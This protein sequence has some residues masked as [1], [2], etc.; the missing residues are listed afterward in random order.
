VLRRRRAR[1]PLQQANGGGGGRTAR[2][3]AMKARLIKRNTARCR[4]QEEHA[5]AIQR[6]TVEAGQEQ[7]ARERRAPRRHG[8]GGVQVHK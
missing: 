2:V 1:P 4:L 8:R 7:R 5:R 6:A 3:V